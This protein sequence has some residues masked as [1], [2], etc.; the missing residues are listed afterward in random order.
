MTLPPFPSFLALSVGVSASLGVV[1]I[2]IVAV[3][4]VAVVRERRR[5]Q[6][7]LGEFKRLRTDYTAANEKAAGFRGEK[8]HILRIIEQQIANPFGELRAQFAHLSTDPALKE[9]AAAWGR[10]S[11]PLDR[12]ARGVETLSE[13]QMLDERSR[14]ISLVTI[15]V[16]AVVLEAVAATREAAEK[17]SIRISLPATSIPSAARGDAM[18]LRKVVS[19]LVY[20]AIEVSPVGSSISLSL[21]QTSDRVL[22]TVSDEG[23][24]AVSGDQAQV[25]MQSGDSRPPMSFSALESPL[26]LA[27]V[28]N[29]VKAMEG[30][31]WSQ[32]EPG[33]GTTHVVELPLPVRAEAAPF[34]ASR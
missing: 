11:G 26:N 18:L 30:W 1:G 25:L 21:Y 24:G 33:R 3:A 5:L 29:L 23:P 14:S 12:I 6:A 31:L 34:T 15:N 20:Q 2:L 8:N 28:H 32:S 7:L 9:S 22:V 4:I 17:K 27:M 16:G 19:T 13:I 10:I